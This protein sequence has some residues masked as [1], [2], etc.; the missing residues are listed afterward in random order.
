[1]PYTGR[2][3]TACIAIRDAFPV[4]TIDSG[5]YV[6]IARSGNIAVVDGG[7]LEIYRSEYLMPDGGIGYMDVIIL[8]VDGERKFN[9]K[10]TGPYPS[11]ML[12]EQWYDDTDPETP[13]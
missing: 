9:I 13:D 10:H 11:A 3:R 5:R 1:M 6:P 8:E 12:D 2:Q 7:V 4:A